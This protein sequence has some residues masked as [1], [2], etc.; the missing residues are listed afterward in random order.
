MKRESKENQNEPQSDF[1][2]E[3]FKF[4]LLDL[5]KFFRERRAKFKLDY[6]DKISE[7]NPKK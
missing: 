3:S 6:F 2:P 1:I 7:T 5:P 4:V